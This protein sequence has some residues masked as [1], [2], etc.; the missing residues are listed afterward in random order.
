[1]FIKFQAYTS[2]R[3]IRDWYEYVI[4]TQVIRNFVQLC[5]HFWPK[6]QNKFLQRAFNK[7][8]LFTFHFQLYNF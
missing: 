2:K 7:I 5:G 4:K 1:M 3:I 8:T 6:I